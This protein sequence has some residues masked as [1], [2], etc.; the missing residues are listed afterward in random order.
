MTAFIETLPP[1]ELLFLVSALMGA[2]G[3]F[4]TTVWLAIAGGLRQDTLESPFAQTPQ[5][6]VFRILLA[7]DGFMMAFGVAGMAL[8]RLAEAA[9]LWAVIGAVGAG[10]MLVGVT[11]SGMQETDIKR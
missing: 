1:V 7:G 2:L 5:K 6:R 10:A 3:I 11:L 9:P 4:I 8:R